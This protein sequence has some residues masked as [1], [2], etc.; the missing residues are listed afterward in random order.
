[1]LLSCFAC[2]CEFAALQ[3]LVSILGNWHSIFKPNSLKCN[4]D[5]CFQTYS[6]YSSFR[7]HIIAAHS[8]LNHAGNVQTTAV[9]QTSNE[10]DIA[11]SD[12]E[13]GVPDQSVDSEMFCPPSVDSH[14]VPPAKA[15]FM[16]QLCA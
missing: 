7:R 15:N 8:K 2:G 12:H 11:D 5:G 9:T 10:I 16:M 4:T 6:T 1:M 13:F 3:N 14:G